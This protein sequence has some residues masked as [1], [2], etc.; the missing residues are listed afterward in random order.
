MVE[1]LQLE[2]GKMKNQDIIKG[3]SCCEN[4]EKNVSWALKNHFP[5]VRRTHVLLVTKVFILL[6]FAH[7]NIE[8]RVKNIESFLEKQTEC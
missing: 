2:V 5:Y 8:Q 3:P 4:V 1:G 6:I 7:D